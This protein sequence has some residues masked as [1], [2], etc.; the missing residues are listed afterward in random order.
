[1]ANIALILRSAVIRPAPPRSPA[2]N[3]LRRVPGLL[4]A[5]MHTVLMFGWYLVPMGSIHTVADSA[6]DAR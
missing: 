6:R 5:P 1:M 3:G 2:R 4:A